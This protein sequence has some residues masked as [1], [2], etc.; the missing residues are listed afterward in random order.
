MVMGRKDY[1]MSF[2]KMIPIGLGLLALLVILIGAH[3]RSNKPANPVELHANQAPYSA[4]GPFQVGVRTQEISANTP[5]E[6]MVWYPGLANTSDNSISYNYEIK[7]QKPLGRVAIATYEGHAVFDAPF[8]LS[9]APYPLVILSPGF[10]IGVSSYGWL[11]EHLASY[12]FVVISPDHSE[13]LDPENELWQAAIARPQDILTVFDY[14]DEQTGAGGHFEG[15]IDPDLVAVTGHSYGGY[16]SLAVAG[17]RIDTQSFRTQCETAIESEEPGNWLCEQLLPHIADMADLAGLDTVPDDLWPAWADARVDA[18]VPMAGNAF[19][20][21][22]VGLSKIIVPV[23][24]IGGTADADSPYMWATHPTYEYISSTTKIKI[25]LNGAEH[26]IFTAPCEKIPW[27][28]K[29]FSGEFCADQSWDRT[30]AHAL[31]KHFTAA[32]LLAELK[33][34]AEAAAVLVQDKIDLPGVDYQS[35]K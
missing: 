23:M 14:V 5:F 25:A 28:L 32:F 3:S 22:P 10:S 8:D 6:I 1:E 17:A 34:D 13:T 21:G 33:H 27:Y 11:A 4:N 31:V 7:M 24:A 20:F 30:Y 16:T 29:M 15:M 35:E 18:I 26:M 9:M 2:G 19:F 12:G